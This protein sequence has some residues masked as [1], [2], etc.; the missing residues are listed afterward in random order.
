MSILK[1]KFLLRR[2]GYNWIKIIAVTI[3]FWWLVQRFAQNK[4]P[5]FGE[6]L[7]TNQQSVLSEDAGFVP[8][9]NNLGLDS[10]GEMGMPV[11]LPKNLTAD[12]KKM[13]DEGWLKNAFNQYV[14]DLISVRRSLPDPRSQ[15]CSD[16][17]KN[18]LPYLPETSVIVIF[19]NE[20]WSTLLRTVHSILDRSPEHLIREIILVDDFSDF[21]HLKTQLEEYM[22]NYPKVKIIR[23]AKREGLI[24]ARMLGAVHAKGPVLT[25]LD[26]HIECT[27]GWLEP[28]LDRIAR[29]TTTVVCPIADDINGSTFKFSYHSNSTVQV[30]GFDWNLQ[31]D[32]HYLPARE[33]QRHKNP[34]EPVWSPTMV[35]C[36]FSIDKAFFEK[37][38]MYDPG[39][40]K[41]I[42]L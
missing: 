14:S 2:R 26:S 18:Y 3:F 28:L 1:T 5:I 4:N 6:L 21:P 34:Y 27:T 39:E 17:E 23:A 29:N 12:E 36:M 42:K 20:A 8:P 32:W 30:G 40:K 31:F 41:D 38:G 16:A 19:H 15:Y 10:P 37:L 33:M 25:F 24:R 22:L 7:D 11:E 35:G 9:S 13:V